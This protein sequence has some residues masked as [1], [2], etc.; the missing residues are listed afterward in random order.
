MKRQL[1]TLALFASLIVLAAIIETQ[2]AKPRAA[3]TAVLKQA[4]DRLPDG[5]ASMVC[6]SVVW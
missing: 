2:E 3:R 1:Q 5:P 4:A 6:S